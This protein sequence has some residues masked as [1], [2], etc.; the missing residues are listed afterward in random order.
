LPQLVQAIESVGPIQ[1]QGAQWGHGAEADTGASVQPRRVEL[2]GGLP[3]ITRVVEEVQVELGVEPDAQLHRGDE[4]GAAE[5][6]PLR[7]ERRGAGQEAAW[8]D[9]E[10]GI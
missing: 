8:R 2:A 5:R 4:E 10:L 1:T 7:V 6:L 9:G 3:H